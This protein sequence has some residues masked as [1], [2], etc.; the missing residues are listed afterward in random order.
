MRMFKLSARDALD[1]DLQRLESER[2]VTI[3]LDELIDL[4]RDPD[5][6]PLTARRGP[7]QAAVDDLA[8]TLGAARRLPDDLTVRVV[9]PEGVVPEPSVAEVEAALRRRAA[10]QA[11]VA[12][13][14]GMAQRAMGLSQL[15]F[16]LALSVASCVA[17]YVFGYLATEVDGVGVGLFA[18]SAMIAIT[19]AWVVSWM[20]VE[21][22]MLD[23]RPGARRAAAYDL[24]ARARVEVRTNPS[25]S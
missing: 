3:E 22:T 9:L 13:R 21:A 11:T 24:L 16:G 8:V 17:A 10:C 7:A 25:V 1:A 14:E 23:W 5:V 2:V 19:I 12:W 18:V 6:D 20:V 4:V 15:P